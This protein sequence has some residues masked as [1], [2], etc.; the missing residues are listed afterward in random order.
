VKNTG[1]LKS[2]L[3]EEA[4]RLVYATSDPE[5]RIEQL[6]VLTEIDRAHVVMLRETGILD[7]RDAAAVLEAIAEARASGFGAMIRRPAPRGIFTAWEDHLIDTIGPAGGALQAGRSRNDLNATISLLSLRPAW[8]RGGE[9]ISGVARSLAEA[10][11]RW[12]AVSMASYTNGQPAVP[13]TLAHWL[14]ACGVAIC[15][16]LS[17]WSSR[18]SA[19]G[20]CPLGAGATGGTTLPIEVA[21]TAG[22]L[23]FTQPLL[24][25]IDAVASRDAHLRLAGTAVAATT[26]LARAARSLIQWT[27]PQLGFLRLPDD[28]SGASSSLP[29]K[30]NPFLLDHIV[31]A[32]AAAMGAYVSSTT[33][34]ASAPFGNEILVNTEAEAASRAGIEALERGAG[35]A[36]LVFGALEADPERMAAAAVAGFTTASA[37]SEKIVARTGTPFRQAHRLV[38]EL[39]GELEREGSGF[40]DRVGAELVPGVV[41]EEE[42]IG[43]AAVCART[44]SGGPNDETIDACIVRIE[45]RIAAWER[46]AAGETRRWNQASTDLDTA[47]EA[48]LRDLDHEEEQR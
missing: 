18:V 37:L 26:T 2:E 44:S 20:Q 40:A 32:Q 14:A 48:L 1:R 41:I 36:A 5:A 39:V 17:E 31:A 47:V 11:D 13:V 27:N 23:G 3:R 34:T 38:G 6:Q 33:A 45:S 25:S 16:D 42:D 9:A 29:Q 8:L 30:R 46:A 21:R 35:L 28:L 19:L 12:R 43:P 22:L 15:R 7:D 4:A 24:N 10:A